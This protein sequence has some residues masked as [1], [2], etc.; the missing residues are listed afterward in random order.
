[1]GRHGISGEPLFSPEQR[2]WLGLE[3]EES[4]RVLSASR[5]TIVLER[6]SPGS[7]ALPWDRELVLMADVRSFAIADLLHLVHASAKSGFLF[8]ENQTHEKSV[9]L[10]RGEVVFATSNHTVDRLGECLLRSGVITLEQHREAKRVFA[11]GRQ[12]GRILVE[13][14]SITPRELWN[15]VKAQVEEIVRSLFSYGAGWV[16]FWEGEVRPDNVVRLSLPTRRLIAEGL[17][18]RDELLKLLAWLETPGIRI[19]ASQ[20]FQGELA[21][22]ERAVFAAVS[23][24][25][26]L[27]D[28]CGKVGLD[29]LSAARTVNHLR[30]SGAVSVSEASPNDEANAQDERRAHGA[31]DS[32]RSSVQAHLMLIEELAA[33][34]VAVEGPDGLQARLA[35]VVEEASPRFPE[36]LSDL[37]VR[38]GGSL[39]PDEVL[40]RA[41][42]FPGDREREVSLAFGEL[43]SYLEFEL[44]NH[45]KIDDPDVFLDAID[46]LLADLRAR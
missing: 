42:R 37:E 32:V 3:A 14:G 9:Y 11:P 31:A 10:H 18:R 45:P 21:G 34:V 27:V 1:M 13:R 2:E 19:A 12:L 24:P 22:T 29:P 15:G 41:L 33:P 20:D 8:F 46:H 43:L 30:L 6:S 26:A 36:L 38:P 16:H 40:E 7:A 5:R 23:G 17:R 35:K 25:A 4:A 28:V 44:V 39:D